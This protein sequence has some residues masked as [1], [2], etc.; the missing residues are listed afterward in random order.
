MVSN[1]RWIEN[2]L[3]KDKRFSL[4]GHK[5]FLKKQFLIQ[6]LLIDT[7]ETSIDQPKKQRT[8]IREKRDSTL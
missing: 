3:I 2:I 4:A 5:A 8:F 1:I 7:T 6:D